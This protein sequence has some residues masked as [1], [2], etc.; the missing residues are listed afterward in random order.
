[1]PKTCVRRDGPQ[2]VYDLGPDDSSSNYGGTDAGS[3][4]SDS[5]GGGAPL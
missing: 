3:S 5:S 2:P 4:D 1:M